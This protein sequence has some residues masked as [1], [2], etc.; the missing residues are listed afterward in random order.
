MRAAFSFARFWAVV[1]KE[2]I[3]MRRDRLTLAMVVG[4][5]VM[6]LI[7]FSYAINTDPKNLPMIVMSG[8]QSPFV[9]TLVT[10]LQ[11]TDYFQVMTDPVTEKEADNLFRRGDVS[12]I[13]HIPEDFTRLLL[14]GER[15]QVLLEAD[16]TDPVTVA[17]AVAAV[18]G[19]VP[20]A[21]DKDLQGELVYLKSTP[22]PIE[23][24][25]HQN[26]NPERV[27]QYNIVPGLLGVILTMMMVFITALA[28]TREKERG[29]MENLLS[30]PVRPLEVMLGKI[31]PYIV[32]GY[33]QVLLILLGARYLF[34]IPMEG[35]IL[36]LLGVTIFFIA[37]NLGV[38]I[39][40]S[41]IATN[42]LQA[43][44]MSIF[45]FLPSLLM[46]GFMFPFRGMPY[47]A[48]CIGNFLPL[49]HYLYV[50]RGILLKGNGWAEISSHV[51]P[52]VAFL[53]VI[54]TVGLFRYH[55]TLD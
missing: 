19:L 33:I 36:L 32:V 54:L 31:L 12:F 37:A 25:V 9:R 6:Q 50:V 26:Y 21:L 8:D 35:S 29:T 5:P 2:F 27:S 1:V 44:Q 14:R 20:S 40:L 24:V 30:M 34:E 10:S 39:T 16:S 22:S 45:F 48:Q 3:Q 51:W 13:F 55:R 15:P 23:L 46:S 41:T 53:L 28:I 49:T 7:L 38:G 43:I 11:L 18:N 17:N 52:I 42:Q 47:W 4:I